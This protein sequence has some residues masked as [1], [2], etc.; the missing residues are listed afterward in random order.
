MTGGARLSRTVGL[1]VLVAG[2]AGGPATGAAASGGASDPPKEKVLGP[3]AIAPPTGDLFTYLTVTTAGGCPGGTNT[4]T[5]VFGP[6]FPAGGENVIGNSEV[7]EFGS[8]PAD[9][10]VAPVTITLEEAR[11]KQPAGTVLDGEY[12]LK[13]NCQEPL[14]SRYDQLYGLYVGS[15]RITPD[16]K[17]SAL[18]TAD[19]LPAKPRPTTGP[20]ARALAERPPVDMELA[21]EA[22]AQAAAADAAAAQAAAQASPV[23]AN[24]GGAVIPLLVAG[25]IIVA[26]GAA[27]GLARRRA[28][29]PAGTRS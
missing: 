8:P 16:G 20:A 3:L 25:S 22:R 13:L 12:K 21:A 28:P 24:S 7:I 4:I 1:A 26:T 18:T 27:V 19:D 29:K 2:A 10:M 9:R 23:R 14:P 15:L 17:Y 11:L 5:R 6:G